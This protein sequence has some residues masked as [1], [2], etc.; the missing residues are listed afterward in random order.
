MFLIFEELHTTTSH[1]PIRQDTEKHV[2]HKDR[3]QHLKA[4]HI[5]AVHPEGSQYL[6]RDA[7]KHLHYGLWRPQLVVILE[8][9]QLIGK[10]DVVF[11]YEGTKSHRTKFAIIRNGREETQADPGFKNFDFDYVKKAT[12]N[13]TKG[14]RAN[15]SE[16]YGYSSLDYERYPDKES[17]CYR[18][19]L[20]SNT[21]GNEE[22]ASMFVSMSDSIRDMDSNADFYDPLHP[23]VEDRKNKFS[24]RIGTAAGLDGE[25]SERIIGEG[26]TLFCNLVPSDL[27]KEE[28][29][30]KD[31]WE[32]RILRHL[33]LEIENFLQDMPIMPHT[34]RKN[35][36]HENFNI[37]ACTSK[38]VILKDQSVLRL[39]GLLYFREVCSHFV[40]RKEIGDVIE[41]HLTSHLREIPME[42]KGEIYPHCAAFAT[43][44]TGWWYFS[45]QTTPQQVR[46]LLNTC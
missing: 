18:P 1:L 44:E 33:E 45:I 30:Q 15:V 25:E 14:S 27:L 4:Y 6:V 22:L 38:F 19:S 21:L 2:L 28:C 12:C 10:I 9:L 40:S 29:G 5:M 3:R 20:K 13:L 32:P 36:P 24:V 16:S 31:T 7:D 46:V 39:G 37:L 42:L 35:C 26:M 43:I 17:G 23:L 41:Q 8:L 34:D 11:P